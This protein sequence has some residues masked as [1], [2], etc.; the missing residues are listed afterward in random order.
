MINRDHRRL[1]RLTLLISLPRGHVPEPPTSC[2]MKAMSEITQ[3]ADR[4]ELS[5]RFLQGHKRGGR[6]K[7]A[8]DRHSRNFLNAFADDFE[9]HGA[10]V[11]AQVREEQPA[12]WLRIAA[13][14]L[15][16][17]AELNVD[18]SVMADVTNVLQAFRVASDLLGVDPASGLKRLRKIA[19]MIEHER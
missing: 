12:V 3:N 14:L 2:M 15:P 18:V 9:Q 1:E 4:D 13:D 17:Q 10:A 11:I 19:P 5:G 7:G 16:K 8:R 6:P